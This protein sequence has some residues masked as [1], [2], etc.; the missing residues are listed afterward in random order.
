M[1]ALVIYDSKSGNTE[2]MARAVAE[3]MASSKDIQVETKKVGERF[4]LTLLAEAAVTVFGSP[5]I[6]ADITHD[7]KNFLENVESYV[8]AR[9]MNPKGKIAAVFGSYGYDG[10]FVMEAFLKKRLQ[11]LGYKVLDTTCVETDNNIKYNP[12][13]LDNCRTFG[14]GVADKAGKQKKA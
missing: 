6:Y 2:K 4:P 13:A 8:S 12:A 1:K 14:R 9:K 7:L 10:A 11:K 5:V 3:G